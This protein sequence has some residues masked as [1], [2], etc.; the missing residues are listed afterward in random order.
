[1]ASHFEPLSNQT[2]KGVTGSALAK[3]C[4]MLQAQRMET[5]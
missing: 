3:P 5:R 4:T 1:M 2:A